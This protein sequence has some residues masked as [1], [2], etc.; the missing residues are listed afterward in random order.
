MTLLLQTMFS[1]LVNGSVYALIGVGIVLCYRSSR[2]VNL[3]QGET[4]M[5]SGVLCAK[6]VGWG[7]PLWLSGLCGVAAAVVASIAFE[8]LALR[9]RLNWDP[10]RL[11]IV[12]VG[13]ALLAEGIADRL[14]GADQLSFP[15]ILNGASL[16]IDGAAISQQDLLLIGVTLAS[17]AGLIVFFRSTLLGHAMTAV[18]ENPRV[19]QLLGV[20]VGRMRQI[21]FGLAGLLGGIAALLLVPQSGTGYDVGL[22]LTLNGFAAAAFANM[23]SP[24]RALAAGMF[25]AVA[26][27]LVGSYVNVSLETPL[28]FG[29]L[30]V[31]GVAYLGR[32]ERYAG[33]ARA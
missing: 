6:M 25:L 11:I 9:S 33:A 15:N 1:S 19:S 27:G 23:V 22:P 30:L 12:T 16:Q 31:I 20:N 5:V 14:I 13:V 18:A 2:V 24:G 3:A 26:E 8:R 17:T 10:S 28:V 21:S 7:Y 32:G 29:V 4:Y